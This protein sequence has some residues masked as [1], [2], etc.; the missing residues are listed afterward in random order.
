MLNSVNAARSIFLVAFA[1]GIAGE[2]AAQPSPSAWQWNVNGNIFAGVNYQNRKDAD[3]NDAE[4][5]NWLMAMGERPLGRARL[6]LHTMF[7]FEPFTLKEIGS[8]QV[9]QTGETFNGV[10]LIDYQH[11]HDLF[12]TLSAT[13][14]RPVGPWT[15]TAMAAAVGTPALGP[16][17]FMHRPSAAENPQSPLGH[18]H[19]DS[20]HITPGVLTLGLSRAGMGIETSVF[21]GREPDEN[22]TDIDLGALD[23]WSLRGSWAKGPWS[24]QLSGARVNE[25]DPSIPGDMTRLIASVAHTRSGPIST[26]LMA[27]WGHNRET[28]GNSNAFLFESNISWLERN[29]LYS[30]A[31]LVGKELPHTHAGIPQPMHE[32]MNIGAFTLGYT[33]D[34]ASKSFGRIG[35]GGDMTMYYV[36]A[37]LQETYGAPLSFH[38]FVRVRFGTAPAGVEHHHH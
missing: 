13:Y 38:G 33:R 16:P 9:F 31:E 35:V 15:L 36:P 37:M 22:R 17:P 29:Y 21:R 4:S 23:S 18:H 26:A 2:A 3:L 32:V 24:A 1:V 6:R 11:P 8:A 7:S 27:A 25:P 20:F 34:L 10:P 14:D 30:R 19:L 28:H 12:T 5:Q